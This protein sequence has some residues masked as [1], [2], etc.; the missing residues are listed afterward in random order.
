[1][2]RCLGFWFVMFVGIIMLAG[3]NSGDGTQ[4][5]AAVP[6]VE[7]SI[8][9]NPSETEVPAGKQIALE[10]N[11]PQG[12]GVTLRWHIEEGGAGGLL[13]KTD[14]PNVIYTAGSREGV[15]IVVVEAI[16]SDGETI[17]ASE[18]ISFNVT[19][20]TMTP[21]P[22]QTPTDTP[23]V[24]PTATVWPVRQPCEAPLISSRILLSDRPVGVWGEIVAPTH[25]AHDVSTPVE[26]VES[27]GRYSTDID[28]ET[29]SL[30][31][32]VYPE[33]GQY[34]P[35]A[36]TRGED[37]TCEAVPMEVGNG[38]WRVSV[39]FGQEGK[40]ERFDLIL[41]MTERGGE[42]DEMSNEWLVN[43]CK[44]GDFPGFERSSLPDGLIEL[45]A[46]TIRTQ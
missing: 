22:T 8:S 18:S 34:Y 40:A 46:I 35:Q 41:V 24:E 29:N 19:L 11:L 14:V 9:I 26:P 25:C 21:E 10:S 1:M 33:N 4:Q 38:Q 6:T 42:F 16:G 12:Q 43:G 7:I 37:E 15:D 20:P 39:A 23:T 36:G 30:W 44:T 45:D 32:L 3:C 17:L 27:F 13:N 2:I 31:V 28:L 5:S